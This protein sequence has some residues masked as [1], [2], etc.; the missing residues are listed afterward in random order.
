MSII[1]RVL[2]QPPDKII[3]ILLFLFAAFQTTLLEFGVVA[4]EELF[5]GGSDVV[6]EGGAADAE[7]A[8]AVIRSA[9]WGTGGLFDA[10]AIC[11]CRV[12][13]RLGMGVW[14]GM[15]G[16][17]KGGTYAA[18]ILNQVIVFIFTS[19][20]SLLLFSTLPFLFPASS[21]LLHFTTSPGW[22]KALNSPSSQIPCLA[23]LQVECLGSLLS[24]DAE[25]SLSW[26]KICV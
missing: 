24:R 18:A 7:G 2:L 25:I 1:L 9:S 6:D 17:G 14:G 16:I 23:S 19:L 11:P 22:Q 12:R 10:R 20:P 3:E 8:A 15:M 5:F 4:Q 26:I 13:K 21:L